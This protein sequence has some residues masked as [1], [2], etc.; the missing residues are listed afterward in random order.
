MYFL[1][2]GKDGKNADSSKLSRLRS[3]NCCTQ[4]LRLNIQK[5]SSF[6]HE[7]SKNS[8]SRHICG[9]LEELDLVKK[10]CRKGYCQLL[11]LCPP[12]GDPIFLS[13]YFPVAGTVGALTEVSL[14]RVSKYLPYISQLSMA[15]QCSQRPYE[16]KHVIK[17]A[18]IVSCEP[19]SLFGTTQLFL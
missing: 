6:Y 9:D 17:I 4:L 1:P 10:V 18:F 13:V 5:L 7:L 15:R 8:I 11:C 3:G 14:N 16:C 19:N 12:D 2:A